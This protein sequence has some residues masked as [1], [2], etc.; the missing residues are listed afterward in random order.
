MSHDRGCPCGRER[1]EYDECKE[2]TCAR[3]DDALRNK[4]FN[5]IPFHEPAPEEE[6]YA[7]RREIPIRDVPLKTSSLPPRLNPEVC[8][9]CG[10]RG[11]VLDSN[12]Q[13]FVQCEDCK[14]PYARSFADEPMSLTERRARQENNAALQTP[15]D[16]IID[17]LRRIDREELELKV[18]VIAYRA[19]GSKHGHTLGGYSSASSSLEETLGTIEAA[20]LEMF[21]DQRNG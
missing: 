4:L 3:R 8:K 7:Y 20:K 16:A 19:V 5:E 21:Y 9:V 17:M 10:G 6:V 2:P 11:A 13:V 15:R 12:H 14:D 1:G 18:V